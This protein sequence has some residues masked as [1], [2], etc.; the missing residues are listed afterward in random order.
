VVQPAHTDEEDIGSRREG[1]YVVWGPPGTGKTTEMARQVE[2]SLPW[3]AKWWPDRRTPVLLCSLTRTAAAEI[4][5]KVHSRLRSIGLAIPDNCI[6]TLHA[7]A[8]RAL[9]HPELTVKHLD[10][11]NEARP[12]YA[13]SRPDATLD[14]LGDCTE[15]ATPGDLVATDYHQRR[16]RLEDRT[17]WRGQVTHFAR[18]W[19]EWKTENGYVDFSD[20][21]EQ[22]HEGTDEALT[23]P[24]IIIADEAQDLSALEFRLLRKWGENAGHL[25]L[26]GDPY[27]ALYTWRGAD[28]GVLMDP[29]IPDKHRRVLSQSHRVPQAVHAMASTWVQQLS[30]YRRVEYAPTDKPGRVKWIQATYREPSQLIRLAEGHIDKG[31]TVMITAA[32][33]YHLAAAIQHLRKRAMPFANPWRLK[34]KRWNPLTQPGITMGKRFLAFLRYDSATFGRKARPWT[35][36]E[37]YHWARPLRAEGLLERGAKL[38]LKEQLPE[39]ADERVDADFFQAFMQDEP[40]QELLGLFA[41]R[42]HAPERPV[43]ELADWWRANLL[44]RPAKRAEFA[45]R[46]AKRRGVE[47]LEQR[48]KLFVG[49][50]HSFKGAEADVV[51]VIPDLS[52]SWLRAW[53]SGRAG[54]DDVVR[55]FYVAITRARQTLYVCRRASWVSVDLARFIPAQANSSRRTGIAEGPVPRT[56]K[57][58]TDTNPAG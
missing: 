16:A 11:W 43:D 58:R 42:R 44:A 51:I 45:C 34:E 12:Q 49:T 40:R 27:Q 47:A 54:R 28:P 39:H 2:R 15:A 31:Q 5:A 13:L 21:I 14:D 56:S 19:E 52:P 4:A 22:A 30:D 9:G 41:A 33:S 55:L 23:R 26:T 48:P 17:T 36:R 29:R 37:L 32:C 25:I 20:L 38:R 3:A 6:G 8:Y 57:A 24:L 53:H 50:V 18:L 10:K 35:Y 46:V 1:I 7:H